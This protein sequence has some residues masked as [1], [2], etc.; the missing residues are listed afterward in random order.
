V[1]TDRTD[2]R[3]NALSKQ[4]ADQVENVAMNLIAA[5]KRLRNKS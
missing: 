5:A 1:Y 4:S 3:T 2:A